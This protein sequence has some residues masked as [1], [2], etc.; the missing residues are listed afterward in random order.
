MRFV[1]AIK[2]HGQMAAGLADT[3]LSDV[4]VQLVLPRLDAASLISLR[5]TCQNLCDLLDNALVTPLWALAI[6]HLLPEPQPCSDDSRC[7]PDAVQ[8]GCSQGHATKACSCKME[9]GRMATWE[10]LRQQVHKQANR[11]RKL[12]TS[13]SIATPFASDSKI[14]S[15]CWSSCGRYLAVISS[16]RLQVW[17]EVNDTMIEVC[18]DG[19]PQGAP[20]AM[21][22]TWVPHRSF[23][24]T[25]K[26]MLVDWSLQCMDVASHRMYEGPKSKLS[27]KPLGPSQV[28]VNNNHDMVAY[29]AEDG[30]CLLK[31]PTLQQ[32]NFFP[33]PQPYVVYDNVR[34]AT[35]AFSPAGSE[36]AIS[37]TLFF[38]TDPRRLE[39]FRMSNGHQ[40]WR[41]DCA[42]DWFEWSPISRHLLVQTS[43]ALLILDVVSGKIVQLAFA[44]GLRFVPGMSPWLH[45]GSSAVLR[46]KAPSGADGLQ[47]CAIQPDGTVAYAWERSLCHPDTKL[48]LLNLLHTSLQVPA[49]LHHDLPLLRTFVKQLPAMMPHSNATGSMWLGS[50][51]IM[52]LST[53]MRLAVVL[54]KH[55]NQSFRSAEPK[56]AQ[57]LIHLQLDIASWTFTC[58]KL[59][60]LKMVSAASPF[61]WHPTA[62]LSRVYAIAGEQHDCGWWMVHRTRFSSTGRALPCICLQHQA[63]RATHSSDG[64]MLCGQTMGASFSYKATTCCWFSDLEL[65]SK[66]RC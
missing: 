57:D 48:P 36:L 35:I 12:Q 61:A 20:Q 34:A 25:R 22:L 42:L 50:H 62:A 30:I 11:L 55:C 58:H 8:Q 59:L 28:A 40:I 6:S 32:I 46:C 2:L 33:P 10:S 1:Q 44:E 16:A 3:S 53:C 52:M 45:D 63:L 21:Q 51:G 13:A 17:K 49:V 60:H 26:R 5:A 14:L 29:K 7:N 19:S 41:A 65:T 24:L 27:R 31:L 38:R 15:A 47:Y 54:P 4:L 39:V 64:N 43:T 18:M 9:E 66:S 37:W 23:L 56:P